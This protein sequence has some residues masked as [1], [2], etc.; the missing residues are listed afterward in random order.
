[1]PGCPGEQLQSGSPSLTPWSGSPRGGA[2]SG[3]RSGP[4]A[5]GFA[6]ADD[7]LRPWAGREAIAPGTC[8]PKHRSRGKASLPPWASAMARAIG[9]PRPA[10]SDERRASSSRTNL[11]K[12]RSHCASGMPPPLSVTATSKASGRAWRCRCTRPPA[13]VWRTALSTRL[14]EHLPEQSLVAHGLEVAPALPVDVDL[15]RGRQHGRFLDAVGDQVVQVEGSEP[16]GQAG[17]VRAREQEHVLDDAREPSHLAGDD[18]E[19]FPVL[20]LGAAFPAATTPPLPCARRTRA[21]AA[22][23]RRRP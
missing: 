10:P 13:G 6:R 9:R 11:S 21:C 3:S 15:P 20:V 8:C 18:A 1:M 17:A 23:E 16:G 2:G 14:I 12:M 5:P 19:R 4:R 22:R 7:R